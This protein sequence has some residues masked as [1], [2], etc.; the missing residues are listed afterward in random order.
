M[1]PRFE[2]PEDFDP[3]WNPPA[4]EFACVA[5]SISLLMPHVEPLFVRTARAALDRLDEPLRSR[6]EEFARQE[7]SHHAEHRRFNQL[8]SHRYGLR[9]SEAAMAAVYGWLWRTR[10]EPFLLAFSAGS[11]TLAYSIARWTHAHV[12]DVLGGAQPQARSLFLWHLGEEVGHKSVAFDI[13]R[14]IVGTRRYYGRA[15]CLSLAILAGFVVSTTFAQLWH[16]RRWWSP[17]AWFRLTR[18]ALSFFMELVP[19][20]VSSALPGHHPDD[21]ADPV[22]A[23]SWAATR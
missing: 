16:D 3:R 5:N 1:A 11:E 15:M 7:A 4:P 20:M 23:R 6:A 17:V 8:L 9:R 18:W 12:T 13:H 19:N 21:L 2:Y 22:L 10:S 14:S